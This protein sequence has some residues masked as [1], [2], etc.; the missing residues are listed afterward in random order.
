MGKGPNARACADGRA[1]VNE[2]LRMNESRR[3]KPWKGSGSDLARQRQRV[4][5]QSGLFSF[6]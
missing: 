5:Q 2:R 6:D 1:G 4:H 3:R